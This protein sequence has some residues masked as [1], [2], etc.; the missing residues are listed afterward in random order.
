MGS[1]PYILSPGT[2]EDLGEVRGL[3]HGAA[4]WLR[5]TKN[6]DQW[7]GPWPDPARHREHMRSDLL[8]GKTWLVRDDAT[9]VG[10]ITLDTDEPCTA[11]GRPVW[12]AHKRHELAV[13]VRR[14]IVSRRY[15]HLGIGAALLDWAAATARRDHGATRV[16]IDVWTTN[17]ALHAY[18]ERQGFTRCP[19]PDPADFIGYPPQALFERRMEQA[20]E[21]HAKLFVQADSPGPHDPA[22]DPGNTLSRPARRD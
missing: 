2:A 15:A 1:V 5:G 18:F 7:S 20:G 6:T 4:S 21:G 16:R 9:V 10:T 8:R 13:Y 19:S 14:V 3:F 11:D 22:G 12:P 17:R